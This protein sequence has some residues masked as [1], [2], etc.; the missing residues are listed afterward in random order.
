MKLT[1]SISLVLPTVQFGNAP[2]SVSATVD[3]ESVDDLRLL[4]LKTNTEA[5]EIGSSLLNFVETE[6]FA[7]KLAL[8][9]HVAKDFNFQLDFS[10]EN[11]K[12]EAA[13]ALLR[14]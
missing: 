6:L 3:T 1:K 13:K 4:G 5:S 10:K 12:N 2:I 7:T 8:E 11:A 14:R 9:E